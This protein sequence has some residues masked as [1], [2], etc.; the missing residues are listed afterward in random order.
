ELPP[1]VFKRKAPN[2]LLTVDYLKKFIG[3]FEGPA[4]SMEIALKQNQLAATVPGQPTCEMKPEKPSIFSIK[5]VP[6]CS[7]EFVSDAAGAIT[8][9]QVHQFGQ[10]FQL[11][12]R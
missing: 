6:G 9:L 2:E 11:R 4:F 8:E 10:I 12:P 1:I 7:L 5:E 3:R